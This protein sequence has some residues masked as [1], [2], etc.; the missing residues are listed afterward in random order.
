MT[1][2][3]RSSHGFW[4]VDDIALVPAGQPAPSTVYTRERARRDQEH[5]LQMKRDNPNCP[6]GY[7]ACPIPGLSSGFEVSC[8]NN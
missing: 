8:A 5:L 2:S 1:M 3:G 6:A 7:L 4:L